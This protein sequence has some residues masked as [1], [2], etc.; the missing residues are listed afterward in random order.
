ML[1]ASDTT[2]QLL[3]SENRLHRMAYFD[4]LTELPNR[5]FFYEHLQHMIAISQRKQHKLA[6]LFLDLDNFKRINDTLG[7]GVGDLVLQETARR[8]R[9]GIRSSDMMVHQGMLQD[10]NTLARLGGDEFT[11]LLSFIDNGE[12]A[13][14]VAERVRQQICLPFELEDQELYTTTS[15]GIAIFP[16]DGLVAGDLLKNADMAMYYSKRDGGDRYSFFSPDMTRGGRA[17]VETRGVIAQG[18]GAWRN[19]KCTISRR[20]DHR[21]W[22]LHQYGGAR[23]LA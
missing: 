17:Q 13:A 18:A 12:D 23:A 3:E 14:I 22:L 2:K 7:H 15:I 4:T 6:I 8:L 20:W 9:N 10:G 5:H 11:V 1:R 21:V 19:R 16:D